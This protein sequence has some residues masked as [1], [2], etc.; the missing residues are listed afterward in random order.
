M[1]LLRNFKACQQ[2]LRI[3]LLE[4]NVEI[5]FFHGAQDHM[6]IHIELEAILPNGQIKHSKF[7]TNIADEKS[8]DKAFS[9]AI[10]VLLESVLLEL[11]NEEE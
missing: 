9:S 8:L 6:H 1:E 4:R 11:M 2:Y 10:D 7:L 5:K 3:K